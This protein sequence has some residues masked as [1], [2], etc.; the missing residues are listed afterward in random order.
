MGLYYVDG[1]FRE[2]FG[3]VGVTDHL[4]ERFIN[5][6]HPQDR[7][8]LLDSIEKV[9]TEPKP[10]DFE[11]RFVTPSGETI[12]FH[13]ESTPIQCANELVFNGMLTNITVQKQ[14]EE[15]R[16]FARAAAG[17][18]RASTVAPGPAPLEEKLRKV[19]DGIVRL[20]RCGR[21]RRRTGGRCHR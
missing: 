3:M 7:Q 5:G 21:N 15:E 9:V 19:T 10:W 6:I 1:K 18:Q 12:W 11:G 17:H 16:K 4:L 13:G 8:R 2:L 20:F 14:A